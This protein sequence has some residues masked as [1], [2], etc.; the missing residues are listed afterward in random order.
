MFFWR[1]SFGG[2]FLLAYIYSLSKFFRDNKVHETSDTAFFPRCLLF[3]SICLAVLLFCVVSMDLGVRVYLH[4]YLSMVAIVTAFSFS[5]ATR[6]PLLGLLGLFSVLFAI[7]HNEFR[8]RVWP[9]VFGALFFIVT[10]G[11][12]LPMKEVD[13]TALGIF[14]LYICAGEAEHGSSLPESW[15]AAGLPPWV[16]ALWMGIIAFGVTKAS[17]HFQS[18][19]S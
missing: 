12:L 4:Y 11:M 19:A 17:L 18:I 8:S 7:S 9:Y 15:L 10:L 6:E 5:Y 14:K 13:D 16:V 2:A 3:T 1:L